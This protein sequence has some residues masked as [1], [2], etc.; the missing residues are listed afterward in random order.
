MGPQGPAGVGLCVSANLSDQLQPVSWFLLLTQ[1][2][3]TRSKKDSSQ[4]MPQ[5]LRR[6]FILS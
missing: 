1:K 3:G 2:Y 4:K 6:S 5:V